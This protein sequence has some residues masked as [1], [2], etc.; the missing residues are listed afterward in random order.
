MALS[1]SYEGAGSI[2]DM[3]GAVTTIF[4]LRNNLLNVLLGISYERALFWHKVLGIAFIAV[5]C[6]HS[7]EGMNF[8]G[9]MMILAMVLMASTYMFKNVS[10]WHA[11]EIFYYIHLV[12]MVLL[13]GMGILHG[14]PFIC[15]SGLIWCID[16]FCRSSA[17]VQSETITAKATQLPGEVIKLTFE[18]PIKYDAGQYAFLRIPVLNKFEFHPFSY[19]SAPQEESM[20]IHIRELGDWTK[21]LGDLVREHDKTTPAASL[22]LEV[23][24]DGS[25]GNHMI[26]LE[27]PEYGCLY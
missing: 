25:Y 3:L 1:V 9:L 5:I 27:S 24:V 4:G 14:S 13:C 26:N 16:V 12:G 6:I 18:R 22:Q 2:G 17:Y 7:L 20:T 15:F 8:S 10:I 21:R 11:F 23:M 19:S